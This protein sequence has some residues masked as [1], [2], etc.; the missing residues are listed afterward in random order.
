MSWATPQAENAAKQVTDELEHGQH[1]PQGHGRYIHWPR[2]TLNGQR[3]NAPTGSCC[4]SRRDKKRKPSS[5]RKGAGRSV[6]NRVR[7]SAWLAS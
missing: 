5:R 7:L 6:Q 3:P 1:L 4:C 2:L